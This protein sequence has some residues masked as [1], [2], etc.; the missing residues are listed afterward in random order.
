MAK[1]QT[2]SNEQGN[3]VSDEKVNKSMASLTFELRHDREKADT[4][5]GGDSLPQREQQ[6]QRLCGKNKFSVFRNRM[7]SSVVGTEPGIKMVGEADGAKSCRVL[8]FWISFQMQ[9]E[10]LVEF[11]GS[12][13]SGKRISLLMQETQE[14]RV[15]SLGQ[16]DSLEEEMTTHSSILGWRIPKKS[17]V[18]YSS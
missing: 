17:L 3:Q 10:D 4:S 1:N 2:Y 8:P 7:K 18:G 12:G 9:R 11:L 13:T 5:S 15:Q 16:K 14:I 6:V